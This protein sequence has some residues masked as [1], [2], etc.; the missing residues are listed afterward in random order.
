MI[1]SHTQISQYLR[2][3]RSYRYRYLDGWQEKET[4]AA[5]AFG[6]ACEKALCAY[7]SD[8]DPSAALFKEWGVYRDTPLEYKSGES[9]DR[10]GNG[11]EHAQWVK[12]G[13]NAGQQ[14]PAGS[15]CSTANST[16]S[17]FTDLAVGMPVYNVHNLLGLLV[18]TY[19]PFA[20][21][22]GGAVD[23][24]DTDGHLLT[25]F[26]TNSAAGPLQGPW[27]VA[28]AP[29]GFGPFSGALLIGNVC[30]GKINAYNPWTHK[31][32]GQLKDTSGNVIAIDE[33][34]ELLFARDRD[35]GGANTLFFTAGPNNYNDGLFGEIVSVDRDE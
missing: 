12:F 33:L 10:L 29:F 7:F 28:L 9:W 21:M 14:P 11:W 35:E 34:W 2:C 27:A 30:D 3:P 24:F 26:T 1:F 8:E 23:V 19:A 5:M 31:F 20:M 4:R 13:S 6:R 22:T 25:Q 17:D 15:T 16:R 18:V 32:L